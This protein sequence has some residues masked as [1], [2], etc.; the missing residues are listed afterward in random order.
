VTRTL[1]FDW[2]GTLALPAAGDLEMYSPLFRRFGIDV[3]VETVARHTE[4]WQGV[5]HHEHSA[6]EASYDRWTRGR[7]LDLV[8]ESG[9]DEDIQLELVDALLDSESPEMAPYEDA[10]PVLEELRSRG[11]S[12]AICSNWSWHL[13]PHVEH[14]GLRPYVGQVLTS[15][16]LGYRKPHPAIFLATLD[17]LGTDPKEVVFIG[18]SCGPDVLGP[19]AAGMQPVHIARNERASDPPLIPGSQRLRT[20]TDLV[21]HV[22]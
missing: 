3:L 10:V 6:T 1:I 12:V 2:Y 8:M 18:D 21:D 15:V 11:L 22:L 13:E 7:V 20:L 19:I 14:C 5:D 9:A 17:A 4:R 16:R